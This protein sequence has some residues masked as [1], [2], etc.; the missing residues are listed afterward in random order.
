MAVDYTNLLKKIVPEKDGEDTLRIRVATVFTVNVNGTLDIIMSSG[1]IVPGVSKLSSA[2]ATAG[3]VVQVISLRG[4]ML[5]IG[6]TGP[7][8]DP[9][10]TG[11]GT[12]AT[13]F[14]TADMRGALAL[15]DKLVN[16]DVTVTRTGAD[17]VATSGN[18]ADTA[19]FTLD[20]IYSPS[21]TVTLG[22]GNGAAS[23]EAIITST[24]VITLRTA[25][26]NIT[27]GSNLRLSTTYLKD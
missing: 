27:T 16:V 9:L 15:S 19:C 3:E 14:S 20:P 12:A 8:V 10:T 18:I 26:S 4:S 2:Y 7:T 22:W 5:V 1:V 11:V 21:R 17:I 13:G 6:G 23:G 25:S 24:G